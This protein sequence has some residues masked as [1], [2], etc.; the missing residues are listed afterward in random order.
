MK[1]EWQH[2]EL[3]PDFQKIRIIHNCRSKVKKREPKVNGGMIT[4]HARDDGSLC[5]L[6]S[7]RVE[8][9]WVPLHHKK[10]VASSE[11]LVYY[12]SYFP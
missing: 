8:A 7:C 12:A 2:A 11:A 4:T 3:S 10:I 5:E 9:M 6:T 1:E